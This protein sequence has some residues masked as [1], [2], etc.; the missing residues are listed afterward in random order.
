M[1][2]SSRPMTLACYAGPACR[3]ATPPAATEETGAKS[4]QGRSQSSERRQ[5]FSTTTTA[6]EKGRAELGEA[7]CFWRGQGGSPLFAAVAKISGREQRAPPLRFFFLGEH[8]H[9]RAHNADA[10]ATNGPFETRNALF[11]GA[12]VGRRTAAA[13]AAGAPV[14]SGAVLGGNNKDQRPGTQRRAQERGRVGGEG[15]EPIA[16]VK[17]ELLRT[18]AQGVGRLQS[19]AFAHRCTLGLAP[20]PPLYPWPAVCIGM[21]AEPQ[22]DV[23]G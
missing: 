10:G 1:P 20:P 6:S 23:C 16:G 18:R 9:K 21:L 22:I 4:K 13:A 7:G 8:R 2:A 15:R 14:F 11:G 5:L 19:G 17:S 12:F 3:P